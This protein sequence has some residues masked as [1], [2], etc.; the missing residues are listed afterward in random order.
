MPLTWALTHLGKPVRDLPHDQIDKMTDDL[1]APVAGATVDRGI[2]HLA[3]H[4]D[5]PRIVWDTTDPTYTGPT[6]RLR[7]PG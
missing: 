4:R 7:T 5:V 2:C 3:V 1:D 6:A